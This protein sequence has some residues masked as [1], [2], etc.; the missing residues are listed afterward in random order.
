MGNGLLVL[1]AD[2][3]AWM[4]NVLLTITCFSKFKRC[5]AS[6]M[7]HHCPSSIACCLFKL[8]AQ[9][10]KLRQKCVV[11]EPQDKDSY[12]SIYLLCFRSNC[13]ILTCFENWTAFRPWRCNCFSYWLQ[14]QNFLLRYLPYSNLGAILHFPEAKPKLEWKE[15]Q[16]PLSRALEYGLRCLSA[17]QDWWK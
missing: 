7:G 17:V 4:S 14:M 2:G 1:E 5:E 13:S 16:L 10:I 8:K 15:H 11:F 3:K 9:K 6:K 12:S